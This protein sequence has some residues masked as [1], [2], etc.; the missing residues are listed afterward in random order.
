[1]LVVDGQEGLQAGDREILMWLRQRHPTKK[2]VLAVNKC[3]NANKADLMASEF[4]ELG[5]EP[6]P[7][8]AIS[9]TGTGDMLD[10]LMRT[11]PPPRSLEQVE[12]DSAPLAI[13]IVGRPNVGEGSELYRFQALLGEY[14][15]YLTALPPPPIWFLFSFGAC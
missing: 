4:W 11:L 14:Y 2:V 7:V 15:F 9:G 13:A 6:L 1:M 5:I 10:A 3:E 8:S 12:G